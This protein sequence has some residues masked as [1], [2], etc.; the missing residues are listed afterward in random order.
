MKIV[1]TFDL[2]LLT[3]AFT[4]DVGDALKAH[5]MAGSEDLERLG[6]GA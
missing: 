2:V 1:D 4:A 6:E 3:R 5:P